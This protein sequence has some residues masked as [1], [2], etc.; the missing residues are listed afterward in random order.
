MINRS[1]KLLRSYKLFGAGFV[2][3][4]MFAAFAESFSV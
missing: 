3:H 2:N 1:T 4:I